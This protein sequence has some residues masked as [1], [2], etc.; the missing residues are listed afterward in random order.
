MSNPNSKLYTSDITE[1]EK[2]SPKY[3]DVEVL[4]A[5][6]KEKL[7]T[8][9]TDGNQDKAYYN[10]DLANQGATDNKKVGNQSSAY[11]AD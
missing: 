11:Y 3:G 10:N 6:D 7:N 2:V 5:S 1:A 4:I 9:D 8:F